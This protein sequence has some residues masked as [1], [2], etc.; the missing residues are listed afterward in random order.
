MLFPN[1]FPFCFHFA[2]VQVIQNQSVGGMFPMFPIFPRSSSLLIEWSVGGHCLLV[3][4]SF[5]FMETLETFAK[6][7]KLLDLAGI[8]ME[9][10]ME[11]SKLKWKHTRPGQRSPT[12][13]TVRGRQRHQSAQKTPPNHAV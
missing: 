4:Y 5:K 10:Q 8:K 2:F 7:L 11:T 1:V 13:E 12:R 3:L 9:T 6:S